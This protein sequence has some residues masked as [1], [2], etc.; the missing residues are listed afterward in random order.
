VAVNNDVVT[1]MLS[2][3][4]TWPG[5]VDAGVVVVIVVV[6]VG[7]MAVID[8]VDMARCRCCCC[9][10]PALSSS[11]TWAT[12][13]GLIYVLSKVHLNSPGIFFI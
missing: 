13:S 11:M 5:V 6:D 7:D 8:V 12:L 1:W 4:L 10:G 9:L 2:T 3:L